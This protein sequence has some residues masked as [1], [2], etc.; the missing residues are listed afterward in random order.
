MTFGNVSLINEEDK[1]RSS[2]NY[3]AS[4]P[5]FSMRKPAAAG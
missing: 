2:W 3:D 4:R 1:G 5:S